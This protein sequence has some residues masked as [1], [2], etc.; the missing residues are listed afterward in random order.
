MSAPVNTPVA[1]PLNTPA[2]NPLHAAW[3]RGV[4]LLQSGE[5]WLMD[6]KRAT[7]GASLARIIYG[8][9]VVVFV[10]AN[11]GVSGFLWGP[12][13]SWT[14]PISHQTTWAFPFV[15]Y[16][17]ADPAW[18]FTLKF[19]LLG[20][21]GLALLVGWHARIAAI[22]VLFLMISLVST[23]PVAADQTDNAFRIL[24]LYFCLTDLSAHWSMDA[25]RRA[26]RVHRGIR[27]PRAPGWRPLISPVYSNVVHNLAIVAVAL[28]IFIIYGVAG[29]SKVPGSWWQD[30]TAVYYPLQL[31]S[32]SPW[33]ALSDLVVTN[34]LAVNIVTYVAVFIQIFF[35]FMLLQRWTRAIALIV[36][37][38]MHAGIG[39]L[40]GIPLFSL[41]MMAADG[42]FVRDTTYAKIE[43][44]VSSRVLPRMPW[45]RRMPGASPRTSSTQTAPTEYISS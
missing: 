26:R 19:L 32:L 14:Q 43:H 34:S 42:I 4:R 44:F 35:A 37:V 41:S 11:L 15:F 22:T 40:M 33:P 45:V 24:L 17:T 38:G 23:N 31:E 3:Q 21:A 16:S 12:G 29:L 27:R 20:L 1:S 5:S 2:K 36:I 25:R 28:Q 10:G 13:S 9:V 8:I 6:A 18:L 7:Y 30:G 39:I